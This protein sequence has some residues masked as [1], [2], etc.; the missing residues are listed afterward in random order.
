MCW[1]DDVEVGYLATCHLLGLG[2]RR[3]AFLGKDSDDMF[4]SPWLRT[5]SGGYEKA[6]RENRIE[7]EPGLIGMTGF[8]I[9]AGD[10]ALEKL[11]MECGRDLDRMPT[12]VFAVSDE[13]AMASCTPRRRNSI[14]IPEDLSVIG[15]DNTTC[16]T[17]ST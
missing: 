17:F 1:S 12:A 15:V 13:V 4:G 14:R 11:W 2:H 16:P 3:I 8:P 10:K 6:L 9:E 7:I 5:G